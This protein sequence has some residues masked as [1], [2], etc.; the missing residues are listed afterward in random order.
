MNINQVKLLKS[1]AKTLVPTRYRPAIAWNYFGLVSRLYRGD[2]VVCPCCN[3]HFR[4]FLPS[5]VNQRP[6]VVCPRCLSLERHRL[7]WLYLQE[8]TN[9]FTQSLKMLHI[10]PEL[11]FYHAFR[12]LPKLDYLP[13]DLDSPLAAVSVDITDIP[14]NDN[15]FDVII[16]NHVL[17]HIDDD[18]KAMSELCRVLKPGGWAIVQSP[19][20]TKR[21]HTVEDAAI[22]SPQ[23]RKAHY[24]H[25][26]HRRIYGQDYKDRLE[27]AGFSVRID[28]YVRELGDDVIQKYRLTKNEYIYLCEK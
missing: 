14:Y 9:L 27:A 13:A 28:E 7:L 3:G 16:C 5:S 26:D 25:D 6:N 17:E 10:A 23:A 24:G 18:R 20:D 19:L 21:A 1:L 8:R 11:C 15:T 22:V 2:Q 12:K 4:Q